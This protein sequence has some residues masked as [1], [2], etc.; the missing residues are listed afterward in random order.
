MRNGDQTYPPQWRA[1]YVLGVL[2]AAWVVAF[3]DRNVINLLVQGVKADLSLSDT[4]FS[5]AQG[6]AF[7]LFFAFGS[8]PIGYLVDRTHRR[9]IIVV[10]ILVWSGA[11]FACGL[12]QSFSMLLV[13]RMLVGAGE[14]CLAPAAFSIVADY[15]R[16]ERRG[17]AMGVM[18]AGSAIGNAISIFL[19]G[20]ILKALGSQM[21]DL[22]LLGLVSP[23]R[24]TFFIIA[25]PGFFVA[26]LLLTVREPRRLGIAPRTTEAASRFWPYLKRHWKTFLMVCG[27][28]TCGMVA[29]HSAIAWIPAVLMRVH[30]V[31]AGT[32][33]IWLGCIVLAVAPLGSFLGGHLADRFSRSAP[34]EGRFRVAFIAFPG[35]FL[36]MLGLITHSLPLLLMS[37]AGFAGLGTM[38]V[39]ASYSILHDLVP[40]DMRGRVVALQLFATNLIGFGLGPTTIALITDRVYR[41]EAMGQYSILTMAFPVCLLGI[42]LAIL[43]IGPQRELRKSLYAA[44][45]TDTGGKSYG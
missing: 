40:A 4:Q 14:A 21:T 43:A 23:T 1:I 27:S 30:K 3:M 13:A 7:S 17:A 25:L 36:A 41:D 2:L 45:V 11:T 31:P 39:A 42:T 18:M 33:G 15:F 19:G 6:V 34:L 32:V 35:L 5:L 20:L 22:P 44:G 38:I 9:N 10:G 26:L 24:L 8:L 29:S 28:L 37:F 12:A 16:P